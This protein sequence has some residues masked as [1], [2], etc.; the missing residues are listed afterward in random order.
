[1]QLEISNQATI[2]E[3]KELFSHACN[4]RKK[5]EQDLLPEYI[6]CF[7]M[8]KELQN[9]LHVYSYDIADQ[10]TVQALVKFP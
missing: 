6:R 5:Y 10:M 3:M 8:G 2:L 9:N 7:C 1:M 4:Q